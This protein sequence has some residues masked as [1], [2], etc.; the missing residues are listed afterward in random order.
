MIAKSINS[1]NTKY[2]FRI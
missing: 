2:R 1:K